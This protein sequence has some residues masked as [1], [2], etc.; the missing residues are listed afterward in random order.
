MK[1]VVSH[2][3]VLA[4]LF[5]LGL[6]GFTMP[7]ASAAPPRIVEKTVERATAANADMEEKTG[8]DRI[9]E[10]ARRKIDE[11]KGREKLLA[12]FHIRRNAKDFYRAT[13][14]TRK[15]ERVILVAADGVL[16][17]V[18]DVRL[19]E[20]KDYRANQDAWYR[21]YDDRMIARE[22][23]LIREAEVVTATVERPERISFDQCPAH[24]RNTLTREAAGDKV[25]N[26]IRYRDHD[27]VI[28][29][30]TLDDGAKKRHMIQVR[31]D[32]TI[33]NEGE[34]TPGG[35][36]VGEDWKPRTI[37]FDD[38]PERVRE[39]VNKAVPRGRIPHVEIV[40]RRDRNFYT[41]EVNTP[42]GDRYLTMNEEGTC[43]AD[44]TDPY[45]V[46]KPR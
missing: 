10:A 18:E 28:Y 25:D 14:Q 34:Y 16:M 5:G 3:L 43:V 8:F 24:V 39:T 26:V 13:V 31:P 12:T 15:S 21:D 7:T 38:L 36:V 40:K 30:T 45:D 29:Q 32:G 46:A 42:Q 37:G 41:V 22:R 44:V 33:F 9:P 4:G 27:Q 35:H 11:V 17:N 1:S 20:L 2:R 19:D 6:S 23:H